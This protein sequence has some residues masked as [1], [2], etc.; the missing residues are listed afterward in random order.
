MGWD[1]RDTYLSLPRVKR[2]GIAKYRMRTQFSLKGN[3]AS[4]IAQFLESANI[5]LVAARLAIGRAADSNTSHFPTMG[6]P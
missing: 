4:A 5:V 1:G 6:D 3:V 2:I